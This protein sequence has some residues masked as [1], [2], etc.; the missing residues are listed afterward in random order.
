MPYDPPPDRPRYA[1]IP[2][3]AKPAAVF[4]HCPPQM[5]PFDWRQEF[6]TL[7]ILAILAG[8][9]GVVLAVIPGTAVA[10]L[11]W[12]WEGFFLCLAAG[13][14]LANVVGLV[15]L[16]AD[17]GAQMRRRGLARLYPQD[18]L[19]LASARI[20]THWLTHAPTRDLDGGPYRADLRWEVGT[21]GLALCAFALE[22]MDADDPGEWE[23]RLIVPRDSWPVNLD[24]PTWAELGVPPGP[25]RMRMERWGGRLAHLVPA[26]CLTGPL[27][28]SSA[29][30]RLPLLGALQAQAQTTEAQGGSN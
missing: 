26:V 7:P 27:S 20:F 28:L 14:T 11:G 30:Q 18:L 15:A 12:G 17:Y 13:A 8:I 16:A 19:E 10:A 6:Q 24:R 25:E 5:A 4:L 9:A 1:F 29:H 2:N 3:P 22:Q 21:N 23:T